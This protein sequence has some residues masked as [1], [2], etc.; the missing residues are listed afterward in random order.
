M[1]VGGIDDISLQEKL[2]DPVAVAGARAAFFLRILFLRRVF[3]SRATCQRYR[4]VR[5]GRNTL[6]GG[7]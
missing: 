7:G 4:S 2:P 1:Y 6:G 3:A 5:N